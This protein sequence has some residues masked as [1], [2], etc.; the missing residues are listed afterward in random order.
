MYQLK[1]KINKLTLNR[2]IF[3]KKKQ[4]EHRKKIYFEIHKNPGCPILVTANSPNIIY[5]IP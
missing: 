3:R 4:T 5:L 2:H 1:K